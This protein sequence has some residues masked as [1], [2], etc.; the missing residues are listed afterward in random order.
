MLADALGI[1]IGLLLA[2]SPLGGILVVIE[3]ALPR[4]V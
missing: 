2:A 3:R 4:R 1:M